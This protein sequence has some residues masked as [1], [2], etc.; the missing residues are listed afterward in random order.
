MLKLKAPPPPV[1][2]AAWRAQS[3]I[4]KASGLMHEQLETL[5]DAEFG[6]IA[7]HKFRTWR[8]MHIPGRA[9][10]GLLEPGLDSAG[11]YFC[12]EGELMSG[13][14]NGWNMGD[15][16]MHNIRMIESVQ[17]RCHFAPGE[18]VVIMIESQPIQRKD[19]ACRIYDAAIGTIESGRVK[20]DDVVDRQPW[21]ETPLPVEVTDA[22][23]VGGGSAVR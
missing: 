18:L 8:S 17:K 9:I 14:L 1:N 2:V 7:N 20:V 12:I 11:N 15:G 19:I 22:V 13:S 4:A 3:H 10:N 6:Q 5:Y 16:H 21:D 23:N